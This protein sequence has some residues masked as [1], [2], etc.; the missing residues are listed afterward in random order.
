[1]TPEATEKATLD[2][3]YCSDYKNWS[4]LNNKPEKKEEMWQIESEEFTA[5]HRNVLGRR[6]VKLA[7]QCRAADL[8]HF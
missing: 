2:T 4:P 7:E 3:G 6:H 8:L 1:M 5:L